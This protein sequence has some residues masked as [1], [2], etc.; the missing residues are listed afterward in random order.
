MLHQFPGR[1]ATAGSEQSMIQNGSGRLDTA[2]RTASAKL[3]IA[4]LVGSGFPGD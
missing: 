4:D 1:D 3:F 2:D